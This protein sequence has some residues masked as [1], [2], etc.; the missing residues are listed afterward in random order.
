M[1]LF[2]YGSNHPGQLAERLGHPV[3]AL[4]GVVTGWERVFRGTSRTWGGTGVASL[5]RRRGAT[6]FGIVT[7]V[8]VK[9]LEILDR[10]EG[11]PFSYTR[12]KIRAFIGEEDRERPVV[13]YLAQSK[14]FNAPSY[15][16]LKAVAMTVS[17]HWRHDDGSPIDPEDFPIR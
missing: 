2:S 15:E 14:T 13:V 6:T 1:Y 5:E 10:H 17:T 16:Y 3:M 7:P 11:V 4:P 9:D 8:T 12:E